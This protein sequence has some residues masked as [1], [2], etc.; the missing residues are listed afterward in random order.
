VLVLAVGAIASAFSPNIWWLIFFRV[1]LGVGIGG[2]YP[3]SSTIMAEYASKRTRG[4]MVTLVFTMQAA[5]L[6]IGPLLAA[7]LIVSG[8]S[9]G[10]TWRLLLA[11]GATRLGRVPDAPQ[12]GVD[13]A[14]SA[15]NGTARGIHRIREPRARRTGGTWLDAPRAGNPRQSECLVP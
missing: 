9:E 12:I 15:G 2:D 8:L 14:I 6:I 1:I 11:F 13:S 7:L 5:G 10:I 3:V 4:I